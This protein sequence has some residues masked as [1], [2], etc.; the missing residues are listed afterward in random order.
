MRSVAVRLFLAALC[1]SAWTPAFAQPS[2]PQEYQVKAA[3]LSSFGRFVEWPT[4]SPAAGASSFSLCVLGQDP[5]GRTL[6]QTIA[7]ATVHD[8]PVAL[9]RIMRVEDGRT[10]H[11]VFVSA[12]EDDELNEVLTA[13]RSSNVLTVGETTQFAERG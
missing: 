12:S 4:A 5:F 8:K 2:R 9:R 13:L 11:I 6:D 7:G 10:C 3:Y 1:A